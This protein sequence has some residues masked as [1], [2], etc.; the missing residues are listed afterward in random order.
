[1]AEHIG[2]TNFLAYCEELRERLRPRCRL[3]NDMVAAQ[4][5]VCGRL[6]NSLINRYVFP[7][8]DPISP[9]ARR[10]ARSNA[11]VSGCAIAGCVVDVERGVIWRQSG[12]R[13]CGTRMPRTHAVPL[14]TTS[15]VSAGTTR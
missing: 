7:D 15:G 9:P 6:P 14:G 10:C 1:M 5:W 11:P 12:S 3:R 13:A 8:G 2:L 4:P